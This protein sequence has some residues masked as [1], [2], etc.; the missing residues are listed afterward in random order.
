[1]SANEINETES[2]A[3][4]E[5][6]N[7]AEYRILGLPG[8]QETTRCTAGLISSVRQGTWERI[9]GHES[10]TIER[11]AGVDGIQGDRGQ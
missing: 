10:L 11:H 2:C 9:G 6:Q 8:N 3:V 7:T 1:M 4:Q 5:C